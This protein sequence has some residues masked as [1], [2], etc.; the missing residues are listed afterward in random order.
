MARTSDARA[1]PCQP[2]SKRPVGPHGS[3]E[4]VSGSRAKLRSLKLPHRTSINFAASLL[5]PGLARFVERVV[6]IQRQAY[7]AESRHPHLAQAMSELLRCRR[8]LTA[9]QMIPSEGDGYRTVLLWSD[10]A[11][12]LSLLALVWRYGQRTPIHDHHAVCIVGLYCGSERETRYERTAPGADT[13]V[14]IGDTT[15]RAGAVTVVP[16]GEREIHWVEAL[17]RHLR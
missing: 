15:L 17:G 16:P 1:L 14:A 9:E 3:I 12:D 11:L 6:A 7:S 10:T 8:L 13:V 5:H 2:R 4:A